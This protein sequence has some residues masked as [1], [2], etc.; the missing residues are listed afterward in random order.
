M[1]GKSSATPV[2]KGVRLK[3]HTTFRIGG[4]AELFAVARDASD[5]V[6]LN[7]EYSPL[8]PITYL[9]RGSNVLVADKGVK[10]LVVLVRTEKTEFSENS[11][12]ADAGVPL[13]SLSAAFTDRSLGGLEFACCIP[14][15]LGGALK[16]NAG[17]HGRCM[18]DAV[19]WVE[20]LRGGEV[21][22]LKNDECGFAYRTSG[23]SKND[24]ILRASLKTKQADKYDLQATVG[25][26]KAFRREHQPTGFSAGSVFKAAD[27]PA[28][29]YIDAAGLKGF[30][31]GGAFVSPI[32]AN[33]IINS[34]FATAENVTTL[35]D[36]IKARVYAVFGVA[37]KEEIIY[38]GEFD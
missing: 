12:I 18:A 21:V 11:C 23:F 5:I 3:N 4:K 31:C 27:R 26:Y 9:G 7:R 22:R 34:G 24:V 19:E 25:K 20:I 14:G 6:N 38:L 35:I 1:Y 17:A 13:C 32:H 10:G 8:C 30:E 15:S 2:K 33:F 28:G 29:Y 16:M 36:E 37:L